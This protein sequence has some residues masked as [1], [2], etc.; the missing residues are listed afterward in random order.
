MPPRA[1]SCGSTG[2]RWPKDFGRSHRGPARR[3]RALRRKAFI[4]PADGKI[5]AINVKDGKKAF[6]ASHYDAGEGTHPSSGTG[7]AAEGKD[8]R[9]RRLCG[10]ASR[11]FVGAIDAK[12]GARAG[13]ST[14]RPIL[15]SP[16]AT[17]GKVSRPRN[18][19]AAAEIPWITGNTDPSLHL[20][21][22]GASQAKPWHRKS[23]GEND[24]QSLLYTD[25]MLAM[26]VNTGKLAWY[27][28]FIP[29]ESFDIDEH[30]EFINVDIPGYATSPVSRWA[31][32]ACCGT[33]I[34]RADN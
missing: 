16:E 8:H 11:C 33:S 14:R 26:D 25:S 32:P 12:T 7:L 18:A 23:R 30:Y 31:R 27:H 10:R 1:I 9:R 15:V 17:R 2:T 4:F 5:D 20:T 24:G 29:G 13:G 19:A 6:E 34:G 3:A 22:W 21:F 28:Q